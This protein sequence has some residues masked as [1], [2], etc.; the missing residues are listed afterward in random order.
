[1][2]S[3][4]IPTHNAKDSLNKLLTLVYRQTVQ[5]DEVIVIDSSSIDG[6]ADI[7]QEHKFKSV[8][9]KRDNFDH[10]GTRSTAGRMAK[11]DILVYLTQDILPADEYAI[12]NLIKPLIEHK[13]IA[14]A[15]GRQLPYPDASPFGSHL[16]LF[17]YPEISVLKSLSD[18]D[19]FGI[20]TPF[21]SNSFA[22]Y[23]RI[24][25]SRIGWFKE[26]LIMGEDSFVAAKLLKAGYKI[27]Y[28]ADAQVYHS[29]SYT[30]FQEF[31]RYFDLGVFHK[32]EDWIIKEFGKV[33]GEGIKYIK[34]EMKYLMFHNKYHLI[35]EFFIRNTL[36]LIGYKLGQNYKR[37]PARLIKNIS[38]HKQWW[39]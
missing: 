27:A 4:I 37:L 33:G 10:G 28:T 11:G 23:K 21:F 35:P 25:L 36:K 13:R 34:S 38:M 3:I 24:T 31:K 22:A 5:P 7:A 32:M 1:M 8:I 6:T 15:Y 29:H 2:V 18:K 17:N 12:E 20:R 9:I 26:N 19:K 16:R 39:E 14:A 30:V